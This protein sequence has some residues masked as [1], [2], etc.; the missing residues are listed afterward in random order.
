MGRKAAEGSG[1][2]RLIARYFK[3]IA[4]HHGAFGLEDDAAV[5]ET[6]SGHDLVVTADA[7]VA[8]VHFFSDDPPDTVARKSLRVNL[9][10]LAAKGARALG[11]LLTLALPKEIGDPWLA[12]FARGLASDAEAF[13][14]P[15]LGG[16]TVRTPGPIAIS[17]C[18][19]GAVA[20]GK[21]VR[22]AGAAPGDRV[23][24]TGTIGDAALG[25]ML[26][27]DPGRAE[28]WGL[29]RHQQDRLAA[30]YLVPEP[31][32]AVA[33][34]IAAHA[35]SAMDVSDGLAGDLGKLCRAS[36]VDVEVDIARVP[37]SDPARAARAKDLA[38]I[39][40]ILTGGD[41]YEIVATVTAGRVATLRQQAAAA[42]VAVTEIGTVVAGQGK[43]RLIG[44]NGKPLALSHP[45]FSHF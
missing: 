24:V 5:L 26:R 44:A 12:P 8:G 11:F 13:G 17:I 25:L 37:L 29:T 4:R 40:A 7:L 9:S 10:D 38:L 28:R 22:R 20:H 33:E 35:S 21:L 34:A 23:V 45:S 19:F 16:D 14:C 36:G 32:N 30:R 43:A 27:R 2:D 6:P 3:P 42:G 39:E 41:D 18:A 31:R 1:E 15:L